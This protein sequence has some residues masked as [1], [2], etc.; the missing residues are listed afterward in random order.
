MLR[1]TSA[2]I[3]LCCQAAFG[4]PSITTWH[5]DNMRTG[6]NLQETI[7]TLS[8]VN[9]TQFGKIFSY[10]VD[11][12]IYAQPLY[13]PHLNIPNKGVHNVIYIATENDSVYAFDADSN[14]EPQPPE[15]C[16]VPLP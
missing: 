9:S 11:G 4:Q 1:G 6:Q 5:N 10:T 7:L 3:L 15:C 16:P 12:N 8:N 2:F 14:S 13:V